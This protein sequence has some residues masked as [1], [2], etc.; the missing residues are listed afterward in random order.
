M[1]EVE[2]E[3]SDDDVEDIIQEAH[4]AGSLPETNR[5]LNQIRKDANKLLI[6]LSE[7][8]LNSPPAF[9]SLAQSIHC[10]HTP[11]QLV[12]FIKYEIYEMLNILFF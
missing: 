2:E 7:I 8:G 1:K 5:S 4:S 11:K 10:G 6:F 3:D 9:I 12:E